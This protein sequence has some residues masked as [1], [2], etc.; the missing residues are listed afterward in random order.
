MNARE[1][2]TFWRCPIFRLAFKLSVL[3]SILNP[4]TIL[5]TTILYMFFPVLPNLEDPNV[6][7]SYA[8]LKSHVMEMRL[9]PVCVFSL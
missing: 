7:A 1:S 4:L 2:A 5:G 8:V 3:Y 9:I 6:L